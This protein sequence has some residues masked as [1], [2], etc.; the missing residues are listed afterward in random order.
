MLVCMTH[1]VCALLFRC[2]ALT[3][4]HSTLI[5]ALLQSKCLSH[6]PSLSILLQ[7][8]TNSVGQAELAAQLRVWQEAAFTPHIP[9]HLLRVYQLLCGAVD[10]VIPEMQLDWRR[11]LGIHMW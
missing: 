3:G 10:A 4:F 11:A 2:N 6:V 1:N 7:A 8:G 5:A 9:H